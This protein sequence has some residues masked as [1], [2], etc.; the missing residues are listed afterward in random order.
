ME[1][2]RDFMIMR[3]INSHLRLHLQHRMIESSLTMS[4]F[5]LL[6]Y[7]EMCRSD[8]CVRSTVVSLTNSCFSVISHGPFAMLGSIYTRVKVTA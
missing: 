2:I 4:N 7:D 6:A 8:I 3:Y 5:K 1:R